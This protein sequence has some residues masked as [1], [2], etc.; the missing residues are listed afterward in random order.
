LFIRAMTD[1]P[2]W[3][4]G[5]MNPQ[6]SQIDTDGERMHDPQISQMSAD[7]GKGGN[8]QTYAIIGAAMA[9]HGELGNGFLEAVYQAALKKEFKYR[10]IPYE[11]ERRLPVHYKG[12]MI[13]EYRADFICYGEVIVEL[14]AV[15]PV[16]AY[17]RGF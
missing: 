6:I 7:V 3:M 2:G 1:R 17:L 5:C 10:N 9:V 16:F 14:K 11:R 12:E 13:G 4:Y 8:P 15:H